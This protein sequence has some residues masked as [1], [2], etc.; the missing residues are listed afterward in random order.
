MNRAARIRGILYGY[1]TIKDSVLVNMDN[2]DPCW[3]EPQ[4]VVDHSDKL[5][6]RLSHKAG[7]FRDW[8]GDKIG[9][10]V[11]LVKADLEAL[12]NIPLSQAQMRMLL[13]MYN[14]AW[15][16]FA[17]ERPL[18]PYMHEYELRARTVSQHVFEF[19]LVCKE[20]AEW[21][22]VTRGFFLTSEAKESI[23]DVIKA[24]DTLSSQDSALMQYVDA[25]RCELNEN[26]E[27]VDGDYN[28]YLVLWH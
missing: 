6:T 18:A 20:Y 14:Q 5:D 15:Y 17:N 27:D 4:G 24:Y 28:D 10:T 12:R 23:N 1:D 19:V 8:L 21:L 22:L 13:Q 26:L 3:Q 7:H 25:N 11:D 2:V 16:S 9:D